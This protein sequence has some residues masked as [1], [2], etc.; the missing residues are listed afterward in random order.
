MKLKVAPVVDADLD[1]VAVFLNSYLNHWISPAAWRRT[2]DV[3]RRFSR[4]NNGMMLLDGESIVG[5][6]NAY[7]SERAVRGRIERFCNLGGWCVLPPHR[8]SGPR[9]LRALLA[10]PGYHFSDLSPSGSVISINERL[11][12]EYLDNRAAL[13][14]THPWPWRPGS[15]T[16]DPAILRSELD[17]PE[18]QLYLD[19][20]TAAPVRHLLLRVDGEKCY[21]VFRVDRRTKATGMLASVLH[22]GNPDVF[23]ALLRPLLGRLLLQ[24]GCVVMLVELRIIGG[25]PPGSILLKSFRPKMYL[26]PTLRPSDIDYFYSE[27]VAVRW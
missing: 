9:L 5:V 25:Q 7:Y 10:Q 1:R 13:V 6:Y 27:L 23:R 2:F 24:Y 22:V 20:A 12:F 11:G 8:R 15:I 19:H 18:L 16:S 14:P 17:G 4:P 26:S 21:L 3:C